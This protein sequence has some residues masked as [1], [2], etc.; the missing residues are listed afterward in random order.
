MEKINKQ[1]EASERFYQRALEIQKEKIDSQAR[2]LARMNRVYTRDVRTAKVKEVLRF[3]L[4][5]IINKIKKNVSREK[6][7]YKAQ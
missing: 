5:V 3:L 2:E 7:P 6:A 1:E 4:S